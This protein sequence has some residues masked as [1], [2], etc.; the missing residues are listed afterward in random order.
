MIHAHANTHSRSLLTRILTYGVIAREALHRYCYNIH[1]NIPV[2]KLL[3]RVNNFFVFQCLKCITHKCSKE[4]SVF[5]G[6]DVVQTVEG[7]IN[8]LFYRMRINVVDLSEMQVYS[9]SG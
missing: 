9:L 2:H 3:K 8:F 6:I 1:F 4:F 5:I 7:N